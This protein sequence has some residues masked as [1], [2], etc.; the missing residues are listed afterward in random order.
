MKCTINGGVT[1][2]TWLGIRRRSLIGPSLNSNAPQKFLSLRLAVALFYLMGVVVF[3]QL[4]TGG[5]RVFGFID[6]TTHI[7][8]GFITFFI[9]IATLIVVVVSKPRFR[10]AISIAVVMVVLILI[11]GLLGFSFLDSNNSSI[12]L[13]HY[14][15]ALLIFGV[16]FSGVFMARR[17]D[18]MSSPPTSPAVKAT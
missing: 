10:P 7:T 4:L 9:A 11:Q 8:S 5:L 6:E 14:T 17:W 13:A 16:A 15:N 12:I 1:F 2:P 3:L 18:G